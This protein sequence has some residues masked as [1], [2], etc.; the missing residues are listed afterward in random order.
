MSQGVFELSLS[1]VPERNDT[2]SS[3]SDGVEQDVFVEG[4]D[5][6]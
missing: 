4:L 6:G 1:G 5:L 3:Y 2:V